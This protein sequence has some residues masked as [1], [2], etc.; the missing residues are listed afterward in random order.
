MKTAVLVAFSALLVGTAAVNAQDPSL[1][2]T[3][4]QKTPQEPPGGKKEGKPEGQRDKTNAI[5]QDP[6]QERR[7]ND[8]TRNGERSAISPSEIPAL[9]R[10]ALRGQEYAGWENG[11]VY[12]T[13]TE[14][15]EVDIVK[16]GLVKRYRF[17]ANGKRLKD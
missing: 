9:L 10:R 8:D 7:I 14:E 2:T 16:S 6:N 1:D 17:D 5:Y 3:N 4:Y 11:H 13:R 15:Y 12:K